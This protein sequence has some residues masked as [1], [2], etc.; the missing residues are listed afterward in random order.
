MHLH[1]DI[2]RGGGGEEGVDDVH[3][4]LTTHPGIVVISPTHLHA[5]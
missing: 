5:L 2:Q 3:V 1:V 4:E